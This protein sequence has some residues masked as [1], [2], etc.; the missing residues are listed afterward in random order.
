MMHDSAQSTSH[1]MWYVRGY[2]SADVITSCI[3]LWGHLTEWLRWWTRNPLGNSRV[4]SNPAVV[5]ARF[6]QMSG[7][8]VISLFTVHTRAGGRAEKS[9]PNG[10]PRRGSANGHGRPGRHG[11]RGLRQSCLPYIRC[12]RSKFSQIRLNIYGFGDGRLWP[13]V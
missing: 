3:L 4:G 13:A 1:T 7:K 2:F 6:L 5:A 8:P 12:L 9:R 10:R 11:R